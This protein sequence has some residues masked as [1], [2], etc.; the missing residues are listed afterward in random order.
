[1]TNILAFESIHILNPLSRYYLAVVKKLLNQEVHTKTRLVLYRLDKDNTL[2]RDKRNLSGTSIGLHAADVDTLSIKF[3]RHLEKS[4]SCDAIQIKNKKLYSLYTRQ[5]KLKLAGILR[6]ALRIQ[7]L[8]NDRESNLEIISD[9][10]TISIMKEAF[11]FLDECPHNVQWNSNPKLTICIT[12]NSILMRAAAIF[13]MLSTPTS[14][15][16]EYFYK[17]VS[18]DVPS[19]LITMPRRRPE[20]F[21]A[22][23]IKNFSNKF[24]IF[25]YSSGF[26]A[27]TPEGY[28]RI[29][30][31]RTMGVLHGLLRLRYLCWNSES[32]I[33]DILIIFKNQSNLSISIDLVNSLLN[34]KIDAH[35]SRL[36]TSVLDNYLAIEARR[37][38][39]FILADIMEEIFYCDDAICPSESE[40]TE[41][42]KLALN[43][44]SKITFKGSNANI[45]YRL[46]NFIA[47]QD[48]YLHTLLDINHSNKVIF[49]ASDPSKEQS[50]RYLTEKFLISHFADMPDLTFVIKTHTQDDG[51]ITHCAYLDAGEPSNILLIGD[52]VQKQNI[53]SKQFHIFDEFNFNAAVA[54][55]DGFLTSS[56]SSI[57]QALILGRK[58]GIVDLFDNGSYSYLVT[59][60][61]AM[62][63]NDE[64]SLS[65]FLDAN[66]PDI[67][68]RTLRYFGLINENNNQ[69]NIE[70]HLQNSLTQYSQDNSRD[71]K[72]T[73]Y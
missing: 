39:I 18:A 15:P 63:V 72:N 70:E 62:L 17:H 30:I 4:K 66:P 6:C 33:A 50:Q 56:S 64:K 13:K 40:F 20:D 48:Y 11:L 19:I 54:V 5:G 25:I 29:K 37:K 23:Y 52:L 10:Q 44:D 49:Y 73:F 65:S 26:L 46:S 35:I 45:Q 7:T 61:A 31:K 67:T 8:S 43:D 53:V 55:C 69:F 68:D 51:R 2:I 3:Y 16:K 12:I 60:N 27:V 21:F 24:N 41:A 57:L 36:Q 59:Y 38:K 42:V 47:K 22:S 14:L 1:M 9:K 58:S 71:R 32:Y 28:K 34:N